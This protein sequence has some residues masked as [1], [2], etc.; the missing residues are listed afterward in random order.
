[1]AAP[2]VPEFSAERVIEIPATRRTGVPPVVTALAI[3]G[4]GK[5]IATGGDDAMVRIWDRETG[6]LKHELKGHTEWVR[7]ARFEPSNKWLI[8]AG[9][10]R[11]VQIWNLESYEGI[12]LASGRGST[13]CMCVSADGTKLIEAGFDDKIRLHDLADRKLLKEFE[14]PSA[15][16]RAMVC[17]PNVDLLAASGRNGK[18]RIWRG[19]DLAAGADLEAHRQRV[20][21]MSIS[22]DGKYLASGGDDRQLI[23]W[24]IASGSEA[25]RLPLRPTKIQS[26]VFCGEG[27]LASSGSDNVIRIWDLNEKT[28]IARFVGH[29]GSVGMLEYHE[30]TGDL[31]SASFDTTVRV[32]KLMSNVKLKV[33]RQPSEEVKE[34]KA[35]R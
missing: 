1:V 21:A 24:D 15:D 17:S 31:V 29:T 34:V 27:M 30:G 35:S 9:H 28:E 10:D 7:V 25:Y 16:I 22:R 5:L 13:Y 14:A 33:A 11:S 18:I 6:E 4:D 8:T 32:W 19:A 2:A 12:A 26:L 20:R 3:N 23:V